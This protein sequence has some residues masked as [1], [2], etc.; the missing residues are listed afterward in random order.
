MCLHDCL[1]SQLGKQLGRKQACLEQGREEEYTYHFTEK[2][3]AEITAAVS[4]IKLSGVCSEQEILKA[5]SSSFVF[6]CANVRHQSRL[7]K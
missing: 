1:Q 3:I 4:K 7:S 5:S 6:P 2:D